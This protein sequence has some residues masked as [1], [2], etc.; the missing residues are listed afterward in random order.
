[1]SRVTPW[2]GSALVVLLGFVAAAHAEDTKEELKQLDTLQ[3][4]DQLRD[5]KSIKKDIE[6]VPNQPI[7]TLIIW[8]DA[9]PTSG[10]APLAVS[11]TADPPEGVSG[12]VYAWQ[13]GDGTSASGQSVSHTFSKP[14]VY[15]VILKVS[16]ASGALGEDEQ[17]IK[18]MK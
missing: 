3:G 18:V 6:N 12:A 1:M 16:N 9:K 7:E 14:G 2:V 4:Y 17:R 8:S 13:F 10:A 11:F 5:E 15:R